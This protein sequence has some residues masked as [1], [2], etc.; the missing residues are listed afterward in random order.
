MITSQ[1]LGYVLNEEDRKFYSSLTHIKEADR[2][3][4]FEEL[5]STRSGN[6]ISTP[7]EITAK[8]AIYLVYS[9][10]I[11]EQGADMALKLNKT[12]EAKDLYQRAQII[13]R[14]ILFEDSLERV[15]SKLENISLVN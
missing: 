15:N 7:L 8:E 2:K 1:D 14:D 3:E 9:A 11:Y 13:F 10:S 6:G 4:K 12:E 5:S